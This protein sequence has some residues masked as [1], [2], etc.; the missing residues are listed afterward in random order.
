MRSCSNTCKLA[1]SWKKRWPSNINVSYREVQK[2]KSTA[3]F[4]GKL[5]K[6]DQIR[7]SFFLYVLILNLPITQAKLLDS[8]MYLFSPRSFDFFNETP[9]RKS[10][11]SNEVE[12]K[13]LPPF[14]CKTE[15]AEKSFCEMK[16][17]SYRMCSKSK[18]YVA[19]L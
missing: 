1:E 3:C 11:F 15:N 2:Y 19:C 6:Q 14:F 5:S 10:S 17:Y 18:L 13:L 9:C 8:S 16:F 7:S 12:T 4:T